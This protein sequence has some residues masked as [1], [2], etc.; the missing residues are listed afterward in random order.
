MQVPGEMLKGGGWM[1][2]FFEFISKVYRGRG[3]KPTDASVKTQ[4]GVYP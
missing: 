3:S 1:A 2:A 4:V